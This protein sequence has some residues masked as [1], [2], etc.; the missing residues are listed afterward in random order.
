MAEEDCRVLLVQSHVVSGY[1]GNK[2]AVFPLQVLG[3]EVDY[4]NSVQFSNHTGYKCFKGQVLNADELK[5]LFDGLKSNNINNYSYL[6]TGYIGSVSFL[7]GVLEMVK[8]FKKVKPDLLYVCDPVMGDRGFM[9]VPKE[10]L[11]VYQEKIIPHADLI[12]PNQYEAELLTGLSIKT[13]ADAIQAMDMF[14]EKGVKSVVLSSCEFDSSSTLVLLG[15]QINVKLVWPHGGSIFT[16]VCVCVCLS[17]CEQDNS[18]TAGLILFLFLNFLLFLLQ[19]ACEKTI[20]TMQA[21]LQRTLD[22][23]QKAAGPGNKA[24]A[25]QRELRLVQ[26]KKDIEEPSVTLKAKSL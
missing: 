10:L 5:E 19:T 3:F 25:A 16:S 11:P 1:V 4:I 23:A 24:T 8:E 2:S 14:H 12:T 17:V 26:S 20:A 22:Y 9:Y 15:S 6:V 13:K 18:R 21:V 7:E